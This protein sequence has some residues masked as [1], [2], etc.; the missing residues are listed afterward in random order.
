MYSKEQS[1]GHMLYIFYSKA[2]RKVDHEILTE[3]SSKY[4]IENVALMSRS[5]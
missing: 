5:L 1:C 4:K 2:E 3:V